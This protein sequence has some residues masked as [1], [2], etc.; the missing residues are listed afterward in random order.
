MRDHCSL[1][2]ELRALDGQEGARRVILARAEETFVV[3]FPEGAF[4]VDTPEDYARLLAATGGAPSPTAR[5][6]I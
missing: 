1:F 4:D 2:P 5:N 6:I 3:R